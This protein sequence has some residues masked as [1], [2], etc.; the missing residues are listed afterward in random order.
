MSASDRYA[1]PMSHNDV[2]KV[3]A[4]LHSLIRRPEDAAVFAVRAAVEAMG[5]RCDPFAAAPSSGTKPDLNRASSGIAITSEATWPTYNMTRADSTGTM[6]LVV[7]MFTW[8][9]PDCLLFF[10]THEIRNGIVSGNPLREVALKFP[11][12]IDAFRVPQAASEWATHAILAQSWPLLAATLQ[13]IPLPILQE[14]ASRLP[15]TLPLPPPPSSSKPSRRATLPSITGP[16]MPGT[17]HDRPPLCRPISA[18]VNLSRG[19][20]EAH[21]TRRASVNVSRAPT[22]SAK[23]VPSN[24]IETVSGTSTGTG[25]A[26]SAPAEQKTEQKES[27]VDLSGAFQQT[28]VET[29]DMHL[30]R[31]VQRVFVAPLEK[32]DPI[33]DATLLS[34]SNAVPLPRVVRYKSPEADARFADLDPLKLLSDQKAKKS[35]DEWIPDWPSSVSSSALRIRVADEPPSTISVESLPSL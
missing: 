19:G 23:P 28:T 33:K 34:F 13:H 11:A 25:T 20:V 3:L 24:V 21:P 4:S 6:I 27:P 9:S 12:A 30:Q 35:L 17:Q 15:A 1:A 18:P 26:K 10:K 14:Q 31:E 8:Q 29:I 22:I 16:A 5:W 2:T 7:R 32:K